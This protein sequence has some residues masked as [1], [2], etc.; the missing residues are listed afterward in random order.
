LIEDKF[1]DVAGIRLHYVEAGAGP[2]VV[3]LHGCPE[4]WYSWRHQIPALAAAGFRVVALDL[5]G[6]NDSDKPPGI[7]AYAV[8]ELVRD[9]AGFLTQ[10]NET[11]CAVVAH[12]WGGIVAWYL[13]MLHPTLVSKLVVLNAPHP[14][15]FFRE[16]KR[17]LTQKLRMTYQL[18]FQLPWFPEFVMR[19]F[20]F[21][22]LR[23]MLK[24]MGRF[25]AEEIEKYV[26]AWS[27]PGALTAMVNYYRAFRRRSP[28]LR[29]MRPIEIPTMLIW[30]ARDP[31]FQ[32]GATE[33]FE[34][35]V[36]NL[37]VERIERAGHFVQTDA[38][39]R[40]NELLLD[41]LRN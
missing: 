23:T 16:L 22:F 37:R 15:P 34:D 38:P 30:G 17:S 2:L 33:N 10:T 4:F 8:A 18:F 31:V 35:V 25:T 27:K 9:V 26:E 3:F 19:R 39:E 1:C 36:P 6:Y 12:D 24:R 11:P 13:A 21:A 28:F 20:R 29:V 5:R 41:F 32:R 14:K 40:V 7:G